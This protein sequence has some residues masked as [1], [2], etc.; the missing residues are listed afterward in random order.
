MNACPKEVQQPPVLI[1]SMHTLTRVLAQAPMVAGWPPQSGPH[2][3]RVA[4]HRRSSGTTCSA[5]EG[6][7]L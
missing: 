4:S 6:P 3:S 1:T 5:E 7:G 2:W